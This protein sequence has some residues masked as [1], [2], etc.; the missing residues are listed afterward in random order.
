MELSRLFTTLTVV[1]L[2]EVVQ[3]I[4]SQTTYNNDITMMT[5]ND[6]TTSV[7]QGNSLTL[8]VQYRSEEPPSAAKFYVLKCNSSDEIIAIVEGTNGSMTFYNYVT[9]VTSFECVVHGNRI[10]RT[11]IDVF[12]MDVETDSV[13]WKY[14]S[15]VGYEI[16]V[17]QPVTRW[18]LVVQ[19]G[20]VVSMVV[21]V[22]ALGCR[23][24]WD[25]VKECLRRP[26][27]IVIGFVCQYG[28][29]PTV[30]I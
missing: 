8:T 20:L 28:I 24:L 5:L 1:V 23:L 16:I 11:F 25:E 15:T 6:S 17:V 30:R 27:G 19:L 21:N 29:T 18:K 26:F 14:N 7:M 12:V 9:N 22:F 3:A 13:L 2:L 10:G 4:A